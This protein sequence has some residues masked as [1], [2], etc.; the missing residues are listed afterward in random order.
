MFAGLELAVTVDVEVPSAGART[1]N[2]DSGLSCPRPVAH[3]RPIAGTAEGE[4]A[5][6]KF[7]TIESKVAIQIQIPSCGLGIKDTKACLTAVPWAYD[8]QVVLVAKI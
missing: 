7:A 4:G 6:V 3:N 5:G 2:P 8:R 1:K